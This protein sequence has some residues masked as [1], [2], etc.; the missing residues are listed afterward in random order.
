M[1][2]RFFTLLLAAS[3][4]TAVGQVQGDVNGD[5]C[6][7]LNDLLDV[8]VSFGN[9]H[10]NDTA[11]LCGQPLVYQGYEYET[12]AIGEQCWFA[13][14]L[15]AEQ[16][17]NGDNIAMAFDMQQWFD[18]ADLG[19]TTRYNDFDYAVGTYS[20]CSDFSFYDDFD[21]EAMRSIFGN[22]YNQAAVDDARKVCPSGWRLPSAFEWNDA[23]EAGAMQ[24]SMNEV[25]QVQWCFGSGGNGSGLNIM[26]SGRYIGAFMRFEHAGQNAYFWTST[27][28]ADFNSDWSDYRLVVS[29]GYWNLPF[30]PV[31][32][33]GVLG[34]DYADGLS[35][36]CVKD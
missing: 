14:N 16:Y 29:R 21:A 25:D 23:L 1:M 27:S 18:F 30:L 24:L 12:I 26:P 19:M 11:W 33:G 36:R 6:V 17:A 15:R 20:T 34:A 22:L 32:G 31:E 13:E 3:C 35:V 8:L 2:N 5:G 9:C 10:S 4:L 28:L 7:Q